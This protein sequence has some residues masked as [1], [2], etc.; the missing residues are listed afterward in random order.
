MSN[1]F[2]TAGGYM[3]MLNTFF[4]LLSIFPNKFFYDNIIINNLFDYNIKKNKI[5][6][7]NKKYNN[8]KKK[9][10]ISDLNNFIKEQEKNRNNMILKLNNKNENINNECKS[11]NKNNSKNY[12]KSDKSINVSAYEKMNNVSKNIMLPYSIGLNLG[13]KK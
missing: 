2:S 11:E 8:S 9:K 13:K 3:Q 4:S 12:I 1:V 5:I 10:Y 6:F 7:K